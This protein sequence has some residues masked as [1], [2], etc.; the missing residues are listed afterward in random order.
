MDFDIDARGLTCPRP[1]IKTKEALGEREGPFTILVDNQAARDN[2]SRFARSSGCEVEVSAHPD[3]FLVRVLPGEKA[4]EAAEKAPV[5]CDVTPARKVL[6][7]G[8]DEIGRGDRELGTALAKAFLYACTE[9][10]DRASC[11]IF[12]NSGVRL[13]TEN[14][15]A[16]EHVRKLENEGAEIVVCGTCLDF[17]GL[18]EKLRVGR[19]SN[20]YEI[21][22]IMMSA[23]RLIV[24]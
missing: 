16:V 3:G 14:D 8:S 24:T 22:S 13:V 17:Y 7:I 21:Q 1:V 4:A 23:D 10:E 11:V 19:V 15:Q 20:M 9:N 12:M 2:V 5:V 18:K 6:F